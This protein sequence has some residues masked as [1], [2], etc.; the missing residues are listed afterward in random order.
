M[1][2]H[3]FADVIARLEQIIAWAKENDSPLGYFAALYYKMTL[4]VRDAVLRG[5]FENGSRMEQMDVVFARRYFD[6]FEA[7][8]S[9]ALPSNS[10]KIAFESVQNNDIAVMQ[11][12]LLGMNAHINLDLCISAAAVR[13]RDAIFGLRKDFMHINH[14]IQS[15]TEQTQ[16]QLAKV[17][18]PFSW[19]DRLFRTEDEGWVGFSVLAARGASW[20]AA[21]LLAFAPDRAAEQVLIAQLDEQ[22]AFF[23]QKLQAPPFW[24][25]LPLRFMRYSENGSVRQKI[26]ILEQI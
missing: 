19:L 26:E 17:W 21:Q 22:V 1:T 16:Q 4:A 20:K 5:E 8:Q 7:W 11:H 6:A 9:G 13:Q 25:R 15:L 12:L 24:L 23:A 10:W 3:N 14:I 18:L 2:I